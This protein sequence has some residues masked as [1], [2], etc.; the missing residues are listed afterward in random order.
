[1]SFVKHPAF[2][3][4]FRTNPDLIHSVQSLGGARNYYE[5]TQ[6]HLIIAQRNQLDGNG[7]DLEGDVSVRQVIPYVTLTK[8]IDNDLHL[9]L[10]RRT[11]KVGEQRLSGKCSIGFGGHIE[12]DEILASR[13]VNSVLDQ[14]HIVALN[15]ERELD[16]E[17]KVMATFEPEQ[18]RPPEQVKA[19]SYLNLPRKVNEAGE[20]ES[21][22]DMDKMHRSQIDKIQ[23]LIL[24][25]TMPEIL[26][27]GLHFEVTIGH[28]LDVASLEDELE[29]IGWMTPQDIHS[30]YGED[31]EAFSRYLIQNHYTR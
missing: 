20:V 18:N 19:G 5:M 1:M 16:E 11:K 15:I 14:K 6:E 27:C 13:P 21:A 3:L 4:G 26:H 17:V 25:Q 9:F 7:K 24:L 8:V 12:L 28:G 10:Y 2:I 29:A 23:S 30:A 31:L 22:L